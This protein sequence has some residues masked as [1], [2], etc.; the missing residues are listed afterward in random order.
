MVHAAKIC[1][2]PGSR[3]QAYVLPS[4]TRIQNPGVARVSVHEGPAPL[5]SSLPDTVPQ[6]KPNLQLL[7]TS[8]MPGERYAAGPYTVQHM[9][10]SSLPPRGLTGAEVS[11]RP[12]HGQGRPGQGASLEGC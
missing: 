5:P 12:A 3:I 9:D 2:E 11:L 10:M 8:S 6:F 4:V 7:Y 1:G